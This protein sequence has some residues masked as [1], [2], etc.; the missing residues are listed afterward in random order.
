MGIGGAALATVIASLLSAGLSF[1]YLVANKS[2][3]RIRPHHFKPSLSVL[4]DIYRVGVPAMVM[5]VTESIVSA[6]FNNVLAGFG[7]V[8][9]AAVGIIFRIADLAWMPIA[10]AAGGLLPVVGFCLGARLWHRLWRAVRLVSVA[11]VAVTGVC[12]AVL[13]VFAPQAIAIF[14]SD[15]ELIRIS[16]PAMRIFLSTMVLVGPEVVVITAFQGLS[17]GKE[18]AVLALVRQLVFFVPALYLLPRIWGITGV[19]L[20]LPVSDIL[21]FVVSMALIMREYRSQKRSG[22]WDIAPVT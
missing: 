3:Y 10:G 17:K 9:L 20:S 8:A 16:V 11:L 14:S 2:V 22:V 18:A 15:P 5:M 12:M 21:A 4:R 7:S 6:L 1:Y 13:E 19:W